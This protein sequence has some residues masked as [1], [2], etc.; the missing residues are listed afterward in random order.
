MGVYSKDFVSS[1]R[2]L[3][4]RAVPKLP[5]AS[6]EADYG[7]ASALYEFFNCVVHFLRWVVER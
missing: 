3:R 4:E 5:A 7:D 6:G 2:E 1:F